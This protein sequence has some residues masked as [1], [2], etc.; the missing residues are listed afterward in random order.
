MPAIRLRADEADIIGTIINIDFDGID[1]YPGHLDPEIL[2]RAT[3]EVEQ[4]SKTTGQGSCPPTPL[5]SLM[6]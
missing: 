1:L 2:S 3:D 6:T 4:S 5:G